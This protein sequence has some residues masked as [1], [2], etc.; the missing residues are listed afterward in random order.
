M[1]AGSYSDTVWRPG[2]PLDPTAKIMPQEEVSQRLLYLEKAFTD[3]QLG[4][5]PISEL[6]R[7]LE[8]SW[9]PDAATLFPAG[10]VTREALA[11]SWAGGSAGSAGTKVSTV[12]GAPDWT[13]VRNGAGDYTVTFPAFKAVPLVIA[14]GVTQV[15]QRCSVK[16][17]STARLLFAADT[18]FDWMVWGK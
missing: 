2:Q 17:T 18:D 5:L 15:F 6:K 8:Q 16:T 3:M 1:P 11:V 13:I 14:T 4:D 10:S 7:E 12:A 9:A